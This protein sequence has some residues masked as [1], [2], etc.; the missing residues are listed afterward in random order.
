MTRVT[1]TGTLGILKAGGL[2]PKDST[3]CFLTFGGGNIFKVATE[4]KKKSNK[5]NF[6]VIYLG[7]S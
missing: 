4:K 3:I 5:E 1:Y 2:P 7:P 6:K